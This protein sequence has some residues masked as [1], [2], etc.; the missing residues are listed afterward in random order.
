[1]LTARQNQPESKAMRMTEVHLPDERDLAERL[2][3]MQAWL[4]KHRYE[5]STFTYFFLPPGMKIRVS[6]KIDGEAKAFAQ[7]FGGSLLDMPR[8]TAQLMT[9]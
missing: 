1:L 9:T 5:P 3:D 4:D 7:R 2:T 8:A 6:F